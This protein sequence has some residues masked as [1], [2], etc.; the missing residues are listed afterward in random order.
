MKKI[1][2]LA[3]FTTQFC[4]GSIN[5]ETIGKTYKNETMFL[6]LKDESV[7]PVSSCTKR[8]ASGLYDQP[9]Y[10]QVKVIKC[11]TSTSSYQDAFARACTLADA[12][13]K[14]ALS[15]AQDT[16]ETTTNGE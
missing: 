12:S 11:A 10:N 7:D 5:N 13:V 15:I 3:A 8:I 1:F 6:E 14:K 9:D 16:S 4:F 2:Y